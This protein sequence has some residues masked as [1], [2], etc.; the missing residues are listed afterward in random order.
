MILIA[1]DA[2]MFRELGAVFL[3]RTGRVVTAENHSIIGGVGGAVAEMLC[4]EYPVRLKRVGIMDKFGESA[5][6]E[7]LFSKYGLT[8]RAVVDAA[9]ALLKAD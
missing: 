6:L 5:A 2:A 1:D 9:K 7:D 8:S 4:E 3:A